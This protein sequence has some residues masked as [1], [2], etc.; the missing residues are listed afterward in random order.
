MLP[1]LLA[2]A[3]PAAAALAS[4]STSTGGADQSALGTFGQW[5]IDVMGMLGAPGIGVLVAAENLFPPIPSEVILPLGGFAAQR[6]EFT[7]IEAI[8]WATLG[9]VVGAFLLY[10]LGR[11]LGHDRMVWLADK[12]PLVDSNDI[13]KTV[14]WFARHGTKAVFFGRMLPIF[15]SLISIPAG[16]EKMPM[17]TFG[18]LT[19]AG[20]LIWN[21]IFVMAGF[22]L[23]SQWDVVLEYADVF[24][25]VIIVLV[26][27][28]VIWWVASKVR[29]HRGLRAAHE[30][31]KDDHELGEGPANPRVG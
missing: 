6:G 27:L 14:T 26:V 9:S 23:G 28:A 8:A 17:L 7:V 12:I 30:A 25:N 20:S 13:T 11:L 5:A 18:L 21:T 31:T 22:F 15:R 1:H 3:A 19:T 4:T 24:Q 29:K 16:I 10:G 2:G